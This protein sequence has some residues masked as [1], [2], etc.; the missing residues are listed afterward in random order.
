[1]KW[2]DKVKC[3]TALEVLFRGKKQGDNNNIYK[4][5]ECARVV[6]LVHISY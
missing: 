1:M 2:A 6:T 5:Y 3:F 4:F